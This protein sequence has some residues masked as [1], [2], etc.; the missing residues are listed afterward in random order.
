MTGA[1][2]PRPPWHPIPLAEILM[3]AGLVSVTVGVLR[4]GGPS[5]APSILLGLGLLGLGVA[6]L[7]LREHLSGVRSHLVLLAFLSTAA[8]HVLAVL[9]APL[10]LVGPGAL[11]FDLALFAAALG[12][13]QGAWKRASRDLVPGGQEG[14]GTLDAHATESGPTVVSIAEE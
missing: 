9:V 7:S 6:E 13:F 10:P 3:L 8:I 4:H 11:A 2:R 12:L 1:E 5:G 14:V